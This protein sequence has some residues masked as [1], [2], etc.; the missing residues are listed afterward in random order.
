MGDLSEFPLGYRLFLKTYGWRRIRPTPWSPL[1]R[2]LAECRVALVTSAGF[3]L[4]DQSP[5]DGSV[6]GG[7]TSF[8]VL[9]ND[10]D[11]S[12]LV[13]CQRSEV[14][15][16]E[17]MQR[18]PNL[19]FPLD[20]LHEL[21]ARGR[22]GTVSPRHLSFMG[23]ITAPGRLIRETAPQAAQLLV[24]DRTDAVLLVPV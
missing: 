6:R 12:R 19:A 14:F 16:H 17:G 1:K 10:A 22:I 21:A 5:F 15:D 8:R 4:P 11:L 20:R 24:E 13:D 18:D 9:P 2:P 3:V 23:S 7:D